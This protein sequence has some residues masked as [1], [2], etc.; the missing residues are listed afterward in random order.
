MSAKRFDSI[1]ETEAVKARRRPLVQRKEAVANK[2]HEWQRQEA[3]V[4]GVETSTRPPAEVDA[5]V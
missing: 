3:A 1:A 2:Y 5:A 4:P